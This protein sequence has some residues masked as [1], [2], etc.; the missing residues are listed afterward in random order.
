M[1]RAVLI[2]ENLIGVRESFLDIAATIR[3]RL[4]L[5][6]VVGRK[7][8]ARLDLDRARLQ[9]FLRI[10]DKG[11]RFIVDIDQPDGVFGHVPVYGCHRCNG[12]AREADG[13][14]EQVPLVL[15][16]AAAPDHIAILVRQHRLHAGQRQRFRCV[17]PADA[18]VRMW[19]AQNARVQHPGQM[20]I[21]CVRRLCRSRVR[22]RQR[23]KQD[24]QP[25]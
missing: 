24:G 21:A 16:I 23:G 5:A 19:A 11:Q 8:A 9:S 10:Q 18:R 17:D 6:L 25:F 22:A 7:I 15:G 2:F 20:E 14:V 13:V 1:H 4:M 3:F 12:I